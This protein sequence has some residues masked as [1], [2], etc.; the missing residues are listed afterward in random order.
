MTGKALDALKRADRVVGYT[1]YIDLIL[2]VIAGKA[3]FSTGMTG[4]V[5]RCRKAIEFA[6]NGEAVAVV[7]SGDAGIYGMAGLIL[8]L[9]EA[10]SLGLKVDVIPGVPAFA[11]GGG[12]ATLFVH[13]LRD[14]GEPGADVKSP[15]F[16]GARGGGSEPG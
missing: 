4:E 16:F 12:G 3:V 15:R 8:E 7:S 5:E 13:A 9:V 10:E 14:Y 11:A 6:N 2:P 1:R